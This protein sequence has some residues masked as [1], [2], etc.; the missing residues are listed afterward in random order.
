MRVEPTKNK[1]IENPEP[2]LNKSES[3]LLS[4]SVQLKN[5]S[6]PPPPTNGAF[7]KILDEAKKDARNN[8][9]ESTS[10]KPAESKT[11]SSKTEKEITRNAQEKKELEKEKNSSQNQSGEKN[12]EENA[13]AQPFLNL[14]SIGKTDVEF[15]APAARSILHI[16]DLERIV[17]TIRT[18][19]FQTNSQALITLK[20][21]VLESL[22]IKITITESGKLKAE[23]LALNKQ[24]KKQI[25]SRKK[26]IIDILRSRSLNFVEVEVLNQQDKS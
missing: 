20:N 26:E 17:S 10:E 2:R 24:I 1:E 4:S 5:V 6:S 21:S 7:A 8:K 25:E 9:S 14:Q 19:K 3:S 12:E 16:A 22:Q 15:T 13:F 23:F 18:E 11:E